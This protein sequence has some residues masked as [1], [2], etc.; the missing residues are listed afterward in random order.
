MCVFFFFCFSSY[1]EQ[2]YLMYLFLVGSYHSLSIVSLSNLYILFSDITL[3]SFHSIVVGWMCAQGKKYPSIWFEIY[4]IFFSFHLS[5]LL[6]S[7]KKW[8]K[9]S[10]FRC[11]HLHQN[12]IFIYFIFVEYLKNKTKIFSC[13]VNPKFSFNIIKWI[14]NKREWIERRRRSRCEKKNK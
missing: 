14:V 6:K 1:R 7:E 5:H 9:R 8:K 10:S 11:R 12:S 4:I 3:N 13:A 2:F